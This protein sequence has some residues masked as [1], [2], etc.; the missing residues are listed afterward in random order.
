M[1]RNTA[2]N[3]SERQINLKILFANVLK[4]WRKVLLIM[5]AFCV[6]VIGYKAYKS[7]GISTS[8]ANTAE[9]DSKLSVT[10]KEIKDTQA[11]IDYLND[12]IKNSE[13]ANIDPYNETE[14]TTNIAIITSSNSDDITSLLKSTNHAN[15]IT[16]AYSTFILKTI[17][18]SEITEKVDLSENS[19]KELIKAQ[20][21]FDADSIT[22]SVVGTDSKETETISNYII[23]QINDEQSQIKSLYGDH[24]VVISKAQT[25]VIVDSTLMAPAPAANSTAPYANNVAMA[26]AMTKLSTMQTTLATQEKN[27]SSLTTATPTTGISKKTLLKYGL[28]GLIVGFFLAVIFYILK[29]VLEEKISSEDDLKTIFDIKILAVLPMNISIR[30]KNKLDIISYRNSDSAYGIGKEIAIEKAMMNISGYAGDK[31]SILL[32]GSD[33]KQNLEELQDKLQALND[34]IKFNV[35]NNINADSNEL[36]KLKDTEGVIIVAERN[37]TRIDDLTKSVET[38][39]N[40]KKEII[41]SIVL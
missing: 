18:Y 36:A 33:L 34:N 21:N 14:T 29:F 31:K 40:W 1:N 26:N 11:S 19:I 3:D 16:Q 30:R 37:V 10:N 27:L 17:D 4:Q 32:I 13:Y 38:I 23:N 9:T 20:P 15:Q 7:M 41:G 12:Y 35:S 25:N 24:T 8:T 39:Y 2:I 22:M 28:L 6:L 5:L